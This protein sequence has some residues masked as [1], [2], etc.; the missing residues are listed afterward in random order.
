MIRL[1]LIAF[2]STASGSAAGLDLQA[3]A[4]PI[5]IQPGQWEIAT[6]MTSVEA[7]GV[8]EEVLQ[9]M[10]AQLASQRQVR[11]QCITPEQARNP[12][13]NLMRNQNVR[14]CE[15]GET[16]WAGGVIRIHATCQPPGGTPARM[17]IEGSYAAQQFD[18][19]IGASTTMPAPVEAGAKVRIDLRG[20]LTGRR[21]GEC[22]R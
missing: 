19:R 11:S 4:R 2:L 16:T 8:P 14:G 10:R 3:S 9:Q 12:A 15:Y 22:R 21:T 18:G 20:R 6:E 5:S 1:F 17:T 7:V 13:A